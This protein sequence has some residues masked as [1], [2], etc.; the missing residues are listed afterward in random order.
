MSENQEKLLLNSA[1]KITKEAESSLG[2]W[3]PES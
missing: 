2:A 1:A 3:G